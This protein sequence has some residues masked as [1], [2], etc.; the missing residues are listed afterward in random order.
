MRLRRRAR[1]WAELTL[2]ATSALASALTIAIPDWIERIF[3][4]DPDHHG[5]LLEAAIVAGLLAATLLFGLLA[6]SEWHQP[7]RVRVA[8]ASARTR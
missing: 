2:A 8:Q 3:G 1:F 5:G 4:I 6:R 7:T